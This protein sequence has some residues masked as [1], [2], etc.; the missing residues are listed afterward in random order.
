MKCYDFAL[1]YEEVKKGVTI[2]VTRTAVLHCGDTDFTLSK[3]SEFLDDM[4]KIYK[5]V[6]RL[7]KTAHYIDVELTVAEYK[8]HGGNSC[9]QLEQLNFDR[10][11]YT[12]SAENDGIHLEADT[13]YTEASHD[14]WLDFERVNILNDI[15]A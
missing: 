14:M 15:A 5:D 13:R 7:A 3:I 1:H 2:S 8:R 10:W 11:Y 6:K 9:G 12:G 4:R